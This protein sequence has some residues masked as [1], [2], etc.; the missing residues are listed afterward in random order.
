MRKGI[1]VVQAAPADPSRED[2]FNDWYS[3]TH[4][5]E[6]LAVEGFVSARRYRLT[7]DD[8]SATHPYLAVYEI[9]AE[10]LAAP[11]RELR[12]RA[13][14]GGSTPSTALRLDPPP[15]TAL[16]ELLD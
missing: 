10:D 2:E 7:G 1:F 8:G 13:A 6:L 4:V 3:G 11:L 9:E 16:Y 15:I 14:E 12:R 5:P